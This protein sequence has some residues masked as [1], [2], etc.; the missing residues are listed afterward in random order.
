MAFA[1]GQ[2]DDAHEDTWRDRNKLV[3]GFCFVLF[4]LYCFGSFITF[5]SEKMVIP[6]NDQLQEPTAHVLGMWGLEGLG[7]RAE[8][9]I[10]LFISLQKT[11]FLPGTE[12]Y[13]AFRG[14][15]KTPKPTKQP[16]SPGK[17][18]QLLSNKLGW[19]MEMPELWWAG[20]GCS[21]VS[22]YCPLVA[23]N[24]KHR[25]RSGTE[26]AL[27]VVG[28]GHLVLIRDSNS[29]RGGGL[30]CSQDATP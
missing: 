21:Q 15:K 24:P 19:G 26:V 1:A 16:N 11:V 25:L 30:S 20:Q 8:K 29:K 17:E 13:V 4:S 2:A 7:G 18:E 3:S 6:G 22:Q 23:R 9:A 12:K 10:A 28:Q 5:P 27:S 14:K